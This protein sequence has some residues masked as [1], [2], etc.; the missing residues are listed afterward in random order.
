MEKYR[1]VIS[2]VRCSL[3]GYHPLN[4]HKSTIERLF[5][6]GS[7]YVEWENSALIL[8]ADI[9]RHDP[10]LLRAIDEFG[11]K[12]NKV[13]IEEIDCPQYY[14][15]SSESSTEYVVTPNSIPWIT[16]PE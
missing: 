13:R 11:T 15:E 8:R 1:V 12:I 2:T 9:P 10:L 4:L 5:D 3:Y 7:E 14:I 6:L 16:I